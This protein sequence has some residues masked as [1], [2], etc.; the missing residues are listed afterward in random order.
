MLILTECNPFRR[1]QPDEFLPPPTLGLFVLLGNFFLKLFF[2][3]EKKTGKR[4]EK[5]KG[6]RIKLPG[7]LILINVTRVMTA[8]SVEL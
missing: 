2:I 7:Q 5:L 3:R 6:V 1:I 8:F 4:M